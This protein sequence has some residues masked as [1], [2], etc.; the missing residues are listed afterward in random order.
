MIEKSL[1]SNTEGCFNMPGLLR[2]GADDIG[3]GTDGELDDATDELELG[4][5]KV[6]IIGAAN[7]VRFSMIFL[8]L[9]KRDILLPLWGAAVLF[10]VPG[11]PNEGL[12]SI[13]FFHTLL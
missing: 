2:T 3:G 13:F 12:E 5:R 9:E 4:A 8:I 10:N 11:A 1:P 6:A 7:Q